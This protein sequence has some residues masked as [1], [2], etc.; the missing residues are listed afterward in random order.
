MAKVLSMVVI[1]DEDWE[2]EEQMAKVSMVVIVDEDW[3]K[4]EQMAKVWS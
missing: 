1:V 2:K 4:E 3:E